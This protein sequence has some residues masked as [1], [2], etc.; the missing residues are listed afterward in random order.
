[1]QLECVATFPPVR[2]WLPS[3]ICEE[4][5]RLYLAAGSE[6]Q[7]VVQAWLCTVVLTE[8]HSHLV[9][10]PLH[11][12]A[13]RPGASRGLTYGDTT[14]AKYHNSPCLSNF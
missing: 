8:E 4:S 5:S 11:A 14:Q 13:C 9:Y 6:S 2:G 7:L 3:A 10:F 12:N 1:M